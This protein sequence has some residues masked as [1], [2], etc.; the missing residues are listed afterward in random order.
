MSDEI[1]LTTR[2]IRVTATGAQDLAD[3]LDVLAYDRLDLYLLVYSMEGT[4]PSVTIKVETSMQNES[5]DNNLWHEIAAFSAI[6]TSNDSDKQSAT[7]GV[8]RYIRWR[9]TALS[10]TGTPAATFIIH[11]VG[12]RN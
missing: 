5:D 3:V 6:T 9:V 10:G 8:L 1:R 7:S 4:S 11:G 2:P 12:R